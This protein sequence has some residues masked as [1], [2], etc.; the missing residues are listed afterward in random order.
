MQQSKRNLWLGGIAV[1]L[2][3]FA[4]YRVFSGT[5]GKP[6]LP[7][8]Y[9]GYGVCLAC[10]QDLTV[11]YEK[12]QAQP[13]RCDACGEEAVYLWWFCNDC[14]YRFIPELIREPGQP[15]RPTPYPVCTH[16]NCTA[17]AGWNPDNPNMVP[18]GQAR[19]PRWP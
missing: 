15:P 14:R 16:C 3:A 10:G 6:D 17:V 7:D 5:S 19:L 1:V 8:R 11:V 9:T 2:L 12:D 18:E 4:A 13:L